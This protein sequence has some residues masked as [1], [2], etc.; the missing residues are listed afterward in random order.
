MVQAFSINLISG[1]LDSILACK[2]LQGQGVRVKAVKFYSVF[3][4][5]R[6]QKKPQAVQED[7]LN[8]YGIEISLE[9][10]TREFLDVVRFPKHGY[11]RWLNPCI[12]CKIFMYRK[13]GEIM[14]REGADFVATGE[15]LNQ[16][17]MSQ[18]GSALKLIERESELEGLVERPL[19]GKLLP[20]T[21]AQ[22][23]G[24]LDRG[25]LLD[26]VGRRR[27][28]QMALAREL[29][30]TDYPTPAGGCLLTDETFARRS[31]DLFVH[32]C[33]DMGAL[34]LL[35]TGRHFRLSET[36]RLIVGRNEAENNLLESFYSSVAGSSAVGS[37][38]IM[39]IDPADVMGPTALLL[40]EREGA[41][42]E[43]A[44]RSAASIVARYSDG[45]GEVRIV[46][47]SAHGETVMD[48]A[49]AAEPLLEARR[50]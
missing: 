8:K 44:V 12:D 15:V 25:K 32:N 33:A 18:R 13:A 36:A 17:P 45:E 26:F 4:P 19:S 7:F 47:R 39:C 6:G 29:G 38:N 3:F 40:G 11:G 9:E 20:L 27:D 43:G 5:L 2:V 22:E 28:R 14:K 21:R 48:A 1:G 46:I 37:A 24:L 23:K 42:V 34:Q 35:N 31:K 16:R 50:I 49:R 41:L 10:V 30:I